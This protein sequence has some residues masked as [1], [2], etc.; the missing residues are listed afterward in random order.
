V[1]PRIEADEVRARIVDVAEEHFRRVGYA[2]TAVA[3]IA[4]VLGMSP[5]NI[6]RYFASKSAI[7]DAICQRLTAQAQGLVEAIVLGPGTASERLMRVA[8]ELHRSNKARLTEE[9]RLHDM[10]QVAMAEN[11]PAI[12][13]HIRE[14]EALFARLIRDGVAA[15][16]FHA[17]DPEEAARTL[18]DCFITVFHPALIAQCAHLDLEAQA[19]A[20]ARFVLR[21]LTNPSPVG[22]TGPEPA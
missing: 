18:F 22:A 13:A 7:N 1:R 8:V 9:H 2:R 5:A 6:Y 21:A 4:A 17:E 19:R 15:G 11:W 20:I 3:D 10:V 14:M 12:E 16:E